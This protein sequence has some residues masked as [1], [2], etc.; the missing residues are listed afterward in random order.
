MFYW[1]LHM[2]IPVLSSKNLNSSVLCRHYID[3]HSVMTDR[4]GWPERAKGI[5]AVGI[6]RW[7]TYEMITRM[8][9]TDWDT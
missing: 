5:C 9:L 4:G 2:N 1:F 3:L 7:G 6:L 8:A